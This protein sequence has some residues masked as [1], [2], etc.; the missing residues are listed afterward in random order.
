MNQSIDKSAP[1][2]VTGASGYIANWIVKLLLE[3]GCTVHG[4]VRNPDKQASVEPLQN[5]A[6][7]APQGTLKI[8]KADLLDEGSFD[9]AMQGCELVMHTASPF[10]VKGFKDAQ[11]ALIK[12]AVQGTRNVLEA[13]NRMESVKRVVLTSSVAAIFGDNADL[14]DNPRGCFT[15]EDWN[16]SSNEHHQPY[17]FSKKLAEQEAWSI[18]KAQNRWR[19]VVVNPGMV[20]G[21]ALTRSSQSTSID[22]LRGLGNG[23]LWPGVPDLR[24]PWVDVRDVAQAHLEAG[25]RPDAEGRHIITNGSPSLIEIAQILKHHFGND[26]RFPLFV[27]P[28]PIAKWFGW[29]LDASAT[30]RFIERNVSHPVR[31]DNTRS[32]ERLG[33]TYTPLETTFTDHFQ[34][35][36][37]DGLV[38]KKRFFI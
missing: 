37:D 19:L 1:I 34:Q 35:L 2:L 3:Q 7:S 14:H 33:L 8:F 6:K 26:Y 24:L 31:F 11:E 22:T 4:T 29:I 28:K 30:P 36:I 13:A 32:I 16:Q 10:V 18:N 15:E 21:P 25:F 27:I 17:S 12:P 23:R 20:G 5:I 9:E 38:R